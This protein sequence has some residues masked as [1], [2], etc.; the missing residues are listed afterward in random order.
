MKFNEKDYEYFDYIVEHKKN[1][2]KAYD[3]LVWAEEVC[4]GSVGARLTDIELEEWFELKNRV[5]TH[6]LSKFTKKE[7]S[8]YR[9]YFYPT[10]QEKTKLDRLSKHKSNIEIDFELAWENHYVNNSHHPEHH[11][12][13][14]MSKID[15]LEM[16]IDWIAMSIKFNNNPFDYFKNKR[17]ELE[18]SFGDKIDYEYVSRILSWVVI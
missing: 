16:C 4:N 18:N 14:K 9:K 17:A 7:F 6:D 13:S 8:A 11:T 12:N 15:M 10:E 3:K 1:V 2:M 5:L